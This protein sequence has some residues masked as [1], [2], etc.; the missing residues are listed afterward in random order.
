MPFI[1]QCIYPGIDSTTT[2]TTAIALE[3]DEDFAISCKPGFDIAVQSV[4][5][6]SIVRPGRHH[7]LYSLIGDMSNWYNLHCASG[8]SGQVVVTINGPVTLDSVIS[9]SLI[10]TIV[11]NLYTYS[12]A[13]FGSL[14]YATAFGLNLITDSTPSFGDTICVDVSVTPLTGDNN[15]SN[16]TYNTCYS[17]VNSY[18]PNY[19]ETYPEYVAPLYDDYFTYTIHFQNTGTAAANNIHLCYSQQ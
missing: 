15:T 5:H 7:N 13:Y 6:S 10:P 19:K 2:L 18:D 11:G 16:N 8:I 3:Q 12:I 4:V 9:G 1:A 17:V 14:N